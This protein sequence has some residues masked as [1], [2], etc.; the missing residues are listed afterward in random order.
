MAPTRLSGPQH[1][2]VGLI[3]ALDKELAAAT[4]VLDEEHKKPQ[5][6]KKHPNDKNA[7]TWGQIGE[8]N[9]VIASL[10]AG[11]YGT[12]SAATTAMMMISS[13]PHIRF[14][15]MVGIGAGI[16]RL[17][18]GIDIRLG[19]VVVSQPIG[20]SPGVVQ[21]DFGKLKTGGRIERVGHLSAP[22][23]VLLKGLQ[24]LK[25]KHIRVDSQI[26][27]ILEETLQRNPKM[28]QPGE[29]GS[30]GF[31][32]QGKENDRL[33]ET[34]SIHTG[35]PIADSTA[36]DQ[37]RALSYGESTNEITRNDRSTEPRIHYGIIASGNLVI[38]DGISR[39]VILHDLE[40]RCI[41][42]EMEAAGLMNNF[43]CLVIRGICDYADAHKNDRWQNYAAATAAAFAKEL[44]DTIDGDDV[45]SAPPMEE[46]IKQLSHEVAQ[47]AHS[48][49]E[50]HKMIQTLE[51]S[52][53]FEELR[54][55]LSPPDPSENYNTALKQRHED[56]GQWF[57]Q[58]TE[59]SLWKSQ[60]NSFLW[61]RGIPGCGKTILS[62]TIVRDLEDKGVQNLLYFFFDF[63]N[64]DKQLFNKALNSLVV[65]L[66]CK[67]EGTQ[68]H[69]DLL[70]ND[71]GNGKS[72]PSV[73]KLCVTFQSMLQQAGEVHIILDALDECQTRKEYPAGGLL[74]W[75][76]ALATSQQTNT[77]LL[78]TGRPEQDITSSIESWAQSQ[79]IILI[80]SE[81]VADDISAY[82]KARVRDN[83]GP[84]KRWK[85]RP[86]V[87]NEIEA[88]LSKKANGMFRWV[89]SL[90]SLSMTLDETYARIL[91]NLPREHEHHTRRLLQFLA[92][93]E[94]PLTI[95][96][97]VDAIAVDIAASPR[98]DQKNRMPVPT[99]IAS[100]CSSLA[101]LTTNDQETGEAALELQ[102]A[103]MSVKDYLLS[104]RVQQSFARDFEEATARACIA[105]VCLAYLLELDKILPTE[106][107]RQS[108]WLAQYSAQYW[109]DHAAVG[110]SVSEKSCALAV[111]FLSCEGAQIN[112]YRLH[113]PDYLGGRGKQNRTNIAPALY[114]ASLGGLCLSVRLLLDK[115]V[116]VNAQGGDYGNA[117]QA[118]SCMGHQKIVQL[119]LD[120]DANV[121]GRGGWYGNAI[122]AASTMGHEKIVQMLLE[123]INDVTA[124]GRILGEAIEAAS[125]KG[126][127]K[128]VQMLLDRIN[129][130]TA[131]GIITSEAIENASAVGNIKIVQM[132]LDKIDDVTAQGIITSDAI[133]AAS[134]LGHEEIVQMLLEKIN[135]VT[136]RGTVGDIKIV[137]MLLDNIDDVTAQGIIT[138]DAIEAA[139]ES[140]YER[141]VQ[142]LL[143]KINDVTAR[144]SILN[145]AIYSASA[146]GHQKIVQMLL[147]RRDE[148]RKRKSPS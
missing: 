145:D 66:Y 137:Q 77:H 16:P 93:S 120:K 32:H 116:N 40:E 54:K 38:K 69:L 6:F 112:C 11:S 56:S 100:Y 67:I 33:F 85:M 25:A 88:G 75:M 142:M 70:Y 27:K 98:F 122:G 39:D 17:A 52:H 18:D 3:T 79:D 134:E 9:V 71:C 102:L 141:I 110:E 140:G 86:E 13:L 82:I 126:H 21:Y 147:D 92:F 26:P 104:D 22:P 53:H 43:P 103:H 2:T 97:A 135:D 37:D 46:V 61:L 47:M 96:E 74:I 136:A 123:K 10:A 41:C 5:N 94:R 4:A 78:V 148:S 90:N 117:L 15:L 114:Y 139:S 106:E 44:L 87:Q 72:Q 7:Y 84:L 95:K 1:Y 59:F 111:D 133:E 23:E 146:M 138:S 91:T 42:F 31:I 30:S 108:Y 89:T 24:V 55:W 34:S 119:L 127:E 132:L 76:E 124:Q 8:H 20:T 115:N 58:S 101:L 14:G 118:A 73:N 51:A 80:Q 62:S 48:N 128:I 29:D 64:R 125:V 60:P 12:V 83:K 36:P 99:E 131:Q 105:Q 49:T 130:V 107:L 113:D 35:T 50:T 81:R 121:N 143:D 57:L 19:D 144:G 28:R 63:T 129:D 68:R 65:Q 45:E 109:M